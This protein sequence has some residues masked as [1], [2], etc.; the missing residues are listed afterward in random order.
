MT[1]RGSRR[2]VV[3]GGGLAGITAAVALVESGADVTLLEARPWLGGATCSFTRDGLVVDNG[4]HV[5]LRCCSAYRGL[6]DRLG[7]TGAVRL[8]D[9][10]DVTV[11]RPAAR[12]AAPGPAAPDRPARPAA[13]GPRAV[14]LPAAFSSRTAQ[15][16]PRR[17]G[18]EASGPGRSRRWT[19]SGSATGWPRRGQDERSRR[20]LWDLFTVSALNIA[21][22][23]ANLALAATVVK[24]ALLGARDAADIGVPAVPLGD[25]HGQAGTD[26]LHRLGAQ[27]QAGR[28]GRGDRGR[29]GPAARDR[30][31]VHGPARPPGWPGR[32][33]AGSG[34]DGR[35]GGRRGRRRAA[36]PGGAAAP[37]GRRRRRPARGGALASSPILNV[38]AVYDRP[39]MR[40]PFVAAVDSPVQWVFDRTGQSGLA[41]DRARSAGQYLAVSVSAA[42]ELVDVPAAR[43]R[44]IFL[45]ALAELFPAA[46]TARVTDFFVTRE[47]RA[48]FRQ[49]PGCER[50]RPAAATA[51][52][53][54]TVAGAWTDTGWPDTM[55]GA[56]RSG[57]NAARELRRALGA[58]GASD[59]QAVPAATSGAAEPRMTAVMPEGVAIARDLVGPALAA[60]VDR[61]TPEVR[62]VAA[63]HLGLTD[64]DGRPT[65][66]GG[67]ALRPALALLS[68]RAAGAGRSAAC[69]RPSRSSWCT[70][71]RCCTTTSWTATP[72]AGTGRRPGRCT[73]S[74]R[75]SWPVTRCSPWPR[76]SCSR[77]RGPQGAWAAR[78]LSAAVLRLIAGQGADL[79]FERRDDVT[80]GECLSMA[81][82]KT[83]ALMACACSIGAVYLGAPPALAMGLAAFGAHVGLAFQLTDD[84]LGIWGAPEITG[85]PVR[86]DLRARKK[87]LPVVAALTSGTGQ[88]RQLG[89]LLGQAR[90]AHRGG[91]GA[92]GQAGRGG[93]RQA[94]DR[95]RGGHPARRG[96]TLPGR[97]RHA[98]R[99]ARRVLRDRP[100]HH[101]QAE[102]GSGG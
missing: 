57:L 1:G 2:V 63:Y 3:V 44:E 83:A 16:S 77:S 67:K 32:G 46:R 74:A 54:L 84:L 66:S 26:L 7:M 19:S 31:H 40:L 45:P 101:H 41:S 87:S 52:A 11:L 64:A 91:P 85:K 51:L 43:L 89:D 20:A 39:V 69:P 79:A 23:D 17:T 50:L 92:R 71:S 95:G 38:H 62:A 4:Q 33:V 93:G 18:D 49:V 78:C 24:T 9:R 99:R 15:G 48:T 22:D 6:L 98:G 58:A 102:L 47:R 97:D 10:F 61:L 76:T 82:D 37:G 56:V 30:P 36:R 65:G 90:A 12:P 88:G 25:L 55:E 42:D 70:T 29:A 14:R 100:V 94:L 28:Q 75:P 27:V 21:G 8:Q 60:S 80:L 34:R 86:S 13:H 35:R 81:G 53:G 59:T 5:F 73:A 96:R 68:A 72:S